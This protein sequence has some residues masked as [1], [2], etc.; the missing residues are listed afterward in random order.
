MLTGDC[1]RDVGPDQVVPASVG[2]E[3][4][5]RGKIAADN[6]LGDGTVIEFW[7]AGHR[8]RSV[9]YKCKYQRSL[10]EST[11]SQPERA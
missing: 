10:D 5:G 1:R 6:P 8:W 7:V 3:S 4:V 11:V 2:R 9:L